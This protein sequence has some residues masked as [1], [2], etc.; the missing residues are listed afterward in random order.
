M[1]NV[2]RYIAEHEVGGDRRDLVQARL[3]EL[4]LDVVLLGE[5]KAAMSLQAGIARLPRCL[6]GELLR[7]VGLGPAGLARVV[8]A[9][10][11]S[12]H[13]RRSLG[14]HVGARDRELNALVLAYRAAEYFTLVRVGSRLREK[15]ARVA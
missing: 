1:Q 14:R 8:Q 11:A 3:A 10:R 7:H 6:G 13:E 15:P 5:A 4:A 12:D 2:L 9:R